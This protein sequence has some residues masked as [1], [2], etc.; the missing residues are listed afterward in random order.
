MYTKM[1]LS[2]PGCGADCSPS[3]SITAVIP[4]DGSK[5]AACEGP[6]AGPLSLG[7]GAGGEGQKRSGGEGGE[8][9]AEKGFSR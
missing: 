1:K 3:D 2:S 4:G 8:H 5:R 9:N 6:D 7:L